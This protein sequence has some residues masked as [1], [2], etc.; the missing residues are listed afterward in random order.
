MPAHLSLLGQVLEQDERALVLLQMI[1]DGYPDL[2]CELVGP[3][4]RLAAGNKL[5]CSETRTNMENQIKIF[6]AFKRR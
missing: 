1:D 6:S 5:V 2:R 3:I 4:S